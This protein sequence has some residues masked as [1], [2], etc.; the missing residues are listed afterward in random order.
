[1]SGLINIIAKLS[2]SSSAGASQ[3]S[4]SGS[5]GASGG[6]SAGSSGNKGHHPEMKKESEAETLGWRK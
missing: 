2:G 3:G 5:A 6:F 4:A 1:M